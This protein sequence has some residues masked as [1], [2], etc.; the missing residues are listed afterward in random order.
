MEEGTSMINHVNYIKSLSE[1]LEAVDDAVAEKG[2]VII[3]ISSL[4]KEYNS[5]MTVLELL[6]K[7][8]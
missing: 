2:L 7:I 4:P 8:N 6:Q 3:L 1:H 5:L